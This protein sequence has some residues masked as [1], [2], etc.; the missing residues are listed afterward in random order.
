MST[1]KNYRWYLDGS[2]IDVHVGVSHLQMIS[3]AA[4]IQ[5]YTLWKNYHSRSS[6]LCYH[7]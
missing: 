1:I 5:F 2:S 4:V 7:K 3:W 6:Q